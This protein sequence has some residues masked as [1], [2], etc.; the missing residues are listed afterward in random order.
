MGSSTENSAFGVTHNPWDTDRVPGGSSGGSAAAVA[1]G[2]APLSLGTDTGGSIRQPAALC[3]VVGHEADLRRRQ[4]LRADRVR[5]RRSTRSARSRSPCATA[6]CSCRSICGQDACDSTSVALP[7]PIAVPIAEQPATACASACPPTCS[8][9]ASS[10]AC[11]R[12]STRRCGRRGA[13]R[14][15]SSRSTLPHAGYALPAYYLIAPAEA[16]ANLSRFDGVRFGLRLEEPGDTVADMYGRTRAAGFGAEVKRRIMLGTYA[17]SAGYYD[18]YYGMAQKVRTLIRADFDA[19]FADVDLIATPTSPTVAFRIGERVDDPWAMYASDV[20]DG[21]GEPGRAARDLDPVRARARGCRSA[22][23]CRP[24]VRREPHPGGG[25]RA[26][27][28]ARL[29]SARRRRWRQRHDRGRLG[30]G[31][32]PRDP[33]PAEHRRRRC[34]APART[35]SAPTRTRSP[36]RSAWAT[37]ARCRRSTPARSRRRSRSASRSTARSPPRCQFHRKNYFYPDSPKAYQISQYDQPICV[38][39]HLD[40]DGARIG[41]TRA[42]LEEDAAKLVHAGGTGGRIAG[43]DSSVVDFNRCGTPLVEIVTEPD[44][45][46]P[47]QAVAFL[48]L[49]K[50]TL[51]TIGVSDCDMEKGSLRCDANVSVRRRGEAGFGTKTELKNMN[52]FKFLGEGMAAEIRAPDRAARVGRGGAPGDAPLRPAGAGAA[53][54][55][56]E[57]G[58]AT[59][60]ATSPSPTWCRSSRAPRRSSGCATGMPELPAARIARFRADHGLSVAGR[61]RPERDARPIADYFEAVAAASRRRQG[62]GRLGAQP[63]RRGRH[64]SPPPALAGRRSA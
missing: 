62:G 8:R 20:L 13:G 27:G 61:G 50:N 19:A 44:L 40:V 54:P 41:I 31:H 11:G 24:G 5:A 29:R 60:T 28:R 55:P 59:T 42:H 22:S 33:R 37:R 15:R 36:A 64:A 7:E 49:L 16:S 38:H 18:A 3:G 35:S 57:G 9:R 43:A 32:R 51:Q 2:F 47:E 23:S 52:S 1:A 39:G 63:A 45:R 58:G 21:A 14:A 34:S 56:L 6:R 17:L 25:A 48:G 53:R 30:A 26:R 12:R 46:S 4:P 10:R